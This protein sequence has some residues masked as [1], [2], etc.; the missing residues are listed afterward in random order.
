MEDKVVDPWY[1]AGE[2]SRA[3]AEVSRCVDDDI[4]EDNFLLTQK[5]THTHTDTHTVQHMVE[6]CS[7]CNT[8]VTQE[9]DR[10][11]RDVGEELDRSW[12]GGGEVVERWWRGGG[13]VVE[14]CCT[15]DAQVLT[16]L[17]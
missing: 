11:W 6:G 4:L 2:D 17:F 8:G 9:L 1:S 5:H 16:W 15:G 10:S 13:V 3:Q 14:W 7:E 12:R